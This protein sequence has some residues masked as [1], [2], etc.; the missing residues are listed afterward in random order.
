VAVH[1]LAKAD[2][3]R[4]D[5]C[6]FAISLGPQYRTSLVVKCQSEEDWCTSLT[7]IFLYSDAFPE[8]SIG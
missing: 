6:T 5:A 3:I 1:T 7:L 4:A 8:L 2:M